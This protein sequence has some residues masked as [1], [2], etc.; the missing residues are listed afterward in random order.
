MAWVE[1]SSKQNSIWNK[2]DQNFPMMVPGLQDVGVESGP[3]ERRREGHGAQSQRES[4]GPCSQA[5]LSPLSLSQP[6][7]EGAESPCF[8]NEET[9]RRLSRAW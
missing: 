7:E 6:Q 5:L 8:T 3:R 2:D 1:F 4:A 9:T